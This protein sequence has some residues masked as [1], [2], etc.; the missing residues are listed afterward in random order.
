VRWR[1]VAGNRV[2]RSTDGGATWQAQATGVT[3]RLTA[4]A[5]PSSTVCWLVG[6]EGVVLRS[7]DGQTWQRVTFPEAIDLTAVLA[8]SDTNATVT[9]ADGRVFSTTDGGETWK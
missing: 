3:G 7:T 5:A 8:T 1:I 6:T 9:A 4:G 2:E